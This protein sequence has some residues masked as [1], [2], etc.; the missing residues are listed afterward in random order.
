LTV[1]QRK[2]HVSDEGHKTNYSHFLGCGPPHYVLGRLGD[3]FVDITEGAYGIFVKEAS[4]WVEWIGVIKLIRE[5]D[6]AG[7]PCYYIPR[8]Q[9]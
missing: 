5:R 2:T 3:I 9:D 6:T 4:H 1:R 7:S 8:M